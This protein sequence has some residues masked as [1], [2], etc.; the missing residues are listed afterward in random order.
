[1]KNTK[2]IAILSNV[3]ITPI[4][5][6]LQNDG[7]E[8]WEA[9]GFGDIIGPLLDENAGLR[10]FA[11]EE[12]YIIVDIS[13]LLVSAL[14]ELDAVQAVNQFTKTLEIALPK[15]TL[16]FISDVICRY[17]PWCS[18]LKAN[19]S[20]SIEASWD[21]S[22]EDL[23]VTRSNVFM[24]PVS[25]DILRI[26][27]V[28]FFSDKLWY[29][30]RL[31]YS[32]Q[33]QKAI[34]DRIA[35][36]AKRLT[37]KKKLLALDLD[38]TLWGGVV[39][40]LGPEGIELSDEH[41]GLIYKDV[42][43]EIMRIHNTGVILALVSKNNPDDVKEV[44]S[45]NDH[46]VIKQ[47]DITIEK[48][49]W[50][51]KDKSLQDI[52][53]ELN[54]GLSSVVFIDDNPTERDLAR[55]ML[56]EVTTLEFPDDIS[57]LP[58]KIRAAYESLFKQDIITQEDKDK[59]EQYA[60][61]AERNELKATYDDF[62]EYLKNLDIR[63]KLVDP[64]ANIDRVAQL[65]GKTNQFNLTV[66][67]PSLSSIKEQMENGKWLVYAF[68]VFDRFGSN[69]ITAV[70]VVD[71]KDD[72]PQIVVYVMSC[73]IMGKRIEDA[74]LRCV[75]NDLKKLGYENLYAE[76]IRSDKNAPVADFY[77]R[78]GYSI[79]ARDDSKISYEISL[80]NLPERDIYV[81]GLE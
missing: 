58:A 52:T 2:R 13:A 1:M 31:P 51:R 73:R 24:L 12:I 36:T 3:N 48:I 35:K 16:V 69:G 65:I 5:L 40:E 25:E 79:I 63:A 46:M 32:A 22:L 53:E 61:N 17:Q 68:D 19:P 8:V 30:A 37:Q 20:R 81:K 62:G 70:V 21:R 26:G 77:E 50:D 74:V 29:F 39:G 34:S 78:M 38:N 6:A 71:V 11:A 49:N 76:Y 75:E 23:C 45:K 10:E 55:G 67:R 41:S 18:D 27:K 9:N 66:R 4:V 14:T 60:A 42:Q 44:F 28:Q 7:L 80:L 33:G 15:N 43:R 64:M 59:V 72:I 54:I 57:E 47:S 56:P